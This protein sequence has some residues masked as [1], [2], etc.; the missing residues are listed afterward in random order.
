M[1]KY[2]VLIIFLLCGCMDKNRNSDLNKVRERINL[3]LTEAVNQILDAL[4]ERFSTVSR[5]MLLY[6]PDKTFV[7][8]KKCRV[9]ITASR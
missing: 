5:S 8:L 3:P 1:S 6:E 9:E 2:M 4:V 7:E